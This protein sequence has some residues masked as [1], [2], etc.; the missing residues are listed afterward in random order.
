MY[1]VAMYSFSFCHTHQYVATVKFNSSQVDK[2]QRTKTSWNINMA[3]VL[4]ME[5]IA[6]ICYK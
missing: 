2:F 6:V 5:V 3:K 4:V 1:S